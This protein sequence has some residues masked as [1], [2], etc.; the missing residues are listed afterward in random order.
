[1]KNSQLIALLKTLPDVEVEFTNSNETYLEFLGINQQIDSK[2]GKVIE[3]QLITED[4]S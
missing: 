4:N 3:I 2:N 1:M